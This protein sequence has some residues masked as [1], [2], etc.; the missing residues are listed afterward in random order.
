MRWDGL[1]FSSLGFIQGGETKEAK[2][3]FL[4]YEIRNKIDFISQSSMES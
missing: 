4:N 1:Y 3:L 2:S